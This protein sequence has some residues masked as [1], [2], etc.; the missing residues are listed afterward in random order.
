MKANSQIGVTT[1]RKESW[2]KVTGRAK[3]NGDIIPIGTLHAKILTSIHSH[4]EILSIDT[5]QAETS[6]G[7]QAVITS[8]QIP[9]LMGGIIEDRPPLAR[10]RVRYFG[11]PVAVV[12][13]NTE[14]EAERAIP[15]IKVNYKPLPVI[16]SIEDAI[17]PDATLIHENL[18]SYVCSTIDVF[19]KA[20]TNIC[21][22][23]NVRKGDMSDGFS[24]SDIILESEFKLPHSDH[25]AME[26]RNSRAEILPSGKVI[27]YTSTQAPTTIQRDLSK[28]FKIQQSNIVVKVPLVGGA[29]GGKSN[30]H[31]EIL[32]Y[33]ASKAVDGKM[34][35]IT[36]TR[37]Q[38][39]MSAPS[40]I[41]VEA[42]LKIGAT[43]DGKIKALESRYYVNC[44]AYS[45]SGPRMTR[46]IASDCSGP[47]NIENIYCDSLTVYTNHT[48]V[49]AYRGFGHTA[50]TFCVERMIDK[51]AKELNMDSLELRL[52]NAISPGD[53]S[54]TQ[55]E[56]TLSNTGDLPKCLNR[57]K[58]LIDWDEGSKIVMDNG[59]IRTKGISC[60]WKTPTS[61]INAS[62]G[63]ILTFT[64]DG[65]I[66]L[67]CA[68]IEIGPG[69]KTEIAQILAEKMKM[70]VSKINVVYDVNTETSPIHWK[71]VASMSTFMA[72]NATLAAA[73]DLIN[74][75]CSFASQ[76]LECSAKDLEVGNQRVY[77]KD[78]PNIFLDFKDIVH[79]YTDPLGFAYG[80]QIIGKGTY[81]MK[82]LTVM[83]KE[84]GI[85]HVGV[86][87]TVGAQAVE[88]EYDPI[89]YS[90]RLLKAATVID[91]GKVINP[92]TAKG[93]IMGGMSMG[94]GLAT[95][96][97]FH[98]DENGILKNTSLRTY[99]LMRFGEQPEYIVD[100][101][102]TPQ[103]DGPFGTRGKGEHGILGIPA[104]FN[105]ALSLAA[106]EDFDKI[107]V[108]PEVIWKAKT[109]GLYDTI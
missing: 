79:G 82:D 16:N 64:P 12:V 46:A 45:G 41:E 31:L 104:A 103:L 10:G 72:G 93:V 54:P 26:I 24:E 5:T 59:N 90:Y 88:I 71:T 35:R 108:T 60:F 49:T 109:G 51:L 13:A 2:D 97:E 81:F 52:K 18:G 100:F 86:S 36:N 34:V 91:V 17:K 21:N 87:W 61:P 22:E 6:S 101:I 85:G 75:L 37:E 23:V 62:S 11:E 14:E 3:Y 30:T 42:K 76:I 77:L 9:I 28:A 65:E 40:K 73:D 68:V 63:V 20:H 92:K 70:D 69:S 107:P 44:G 48:Y 25:I 98:F 95:R 106:D 50:F 7:V 105:N 80:K 29:F 74:Q 43:K 56:I 102:E 47:Y 53:L 83:N 4:A 1:I 89:K 27:I 57:L 58:E 8:E 33:I 19:P 99:K 94:I 32:A 84:T 96:E 67:N 15:L 66:N 38:D 55:T 78:N 39:I